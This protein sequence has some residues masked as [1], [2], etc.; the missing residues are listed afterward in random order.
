MT[1]T[2]GCC[3]KPDEFPA[4]SPP[5]CYIS[6]IVQPTAGDS[7][8]TRM[9]LTLMFLGL[10]A[11]AI[12]APLR[13]DVLLIEEVRQSERMKLPENGASM[14]EVRARYGDPANASAAVGDP[15]ISRWDYDR[16]SVYFEYETVLF[17]VL[18]KGAVLD[19]KADD[20][21]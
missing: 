7:H 21:N 16:W 5:P 13:A 2:S 14:E 9:I 11:A 18:H 19:E 8:V 17:T 10:L 12:G 6:V 15:P 3:S 4:D 20:G 1:H